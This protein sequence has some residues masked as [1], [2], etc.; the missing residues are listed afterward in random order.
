[1]LT[2]ESKP[3][4]KQKNA[5]VIGG[6]VILTFVAIIGGALTLGAWLLLSDQNF[7]FAI[8]RFGIMCNIDPIQN[9]SVIQPISDSKTQ[10]E[11][12]R[13]N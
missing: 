1:M 6:A 8:E 9:E 4:L 11:K 3:V 10:Y 12:P 7:A 2:G 13:W 5:K